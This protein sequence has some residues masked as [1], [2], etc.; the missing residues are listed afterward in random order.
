MILLIPLSAVLLV[1]SMVWVGTESAIAY[2]SYVLSAYTLTVWCVKLPRLIRFVKAFKDENRYARRIRSD[3]RL[4]VNI[5]LY[6]SLA[7]NALYGI[8]Q[9]GLGYYHRTFWFTSL[10][11][12][13]MILG[14]MRFSLLLHTRKYAPGE[15]MR[16]ELVKYRACGWVFLVMNLALSVMVLMMVFAGRTFEHHQITTIAMAAYTFGSMAMAIVGLIR[17]R[18][19]NSPIYSAAK[20]VS[21]AAACVSMLTLESTMLTTFGGDTMSAL[22]VS[23]MLGAT[24]AA[25]CIFIVGAAIYMIVTGT[26][27]MKNIKER[28]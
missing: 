12:Y 16:S 19:Y 24:G 22:E 26:A 9:L 5:S 4:R 14:V 18:K 3:P 20:A 13:Y 17:Y 2:V 27:K 23:I 28:N 11:T 8:F 25:V 10:G 21:L 7:W 6:G 1:G 15:R